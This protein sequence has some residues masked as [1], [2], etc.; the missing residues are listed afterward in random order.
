MKNINW[1][2]G[3]GEFIGF[4]IASIGLL[5]F[6]IMILGVSLLNNTSE[7]MENA[8]S[9]I[10][11]QVV[12]CDSIEEARADA[13]T[14]AEYI[15]KDN[16]TI[17]PGTVKTEIEFAPGSDQEW[18]KGNFINIYL[19]AELVSTTPATSGVKEVSAL[20]MIENDGEDEDNT[21]I[22]ESMN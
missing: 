18:K 16:H 12:T 17:T 22:F 3:A 21:V 7:I 9:E 10:G 4:T 15:F 14:I 13:Q 2:K 5:S 19:S 20:L 11:R 6:L 1:K 8:V